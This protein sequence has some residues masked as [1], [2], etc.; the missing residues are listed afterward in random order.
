[1]KSEKGQA[2][3]ESLITTPMCFIFIGFVFCFSYLIYAKEISS[4]F[5]Y[6]AL[7]C[8]EE[9]E[10]SSKTCLVQLEKD[11]KKHLFFHKNLKIKSKDSN[12]VKKIFLKATVFNSKTQY[13]RTLR[14]GQP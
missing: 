10:T 7:I 8:T 2:L 4:Y 6:R 14:I 11:L 9:F 1:M 5:M 13:K 3:I 12:R